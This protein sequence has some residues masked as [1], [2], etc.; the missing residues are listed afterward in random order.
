ME[1]FRTLVRA[2]FL[3]RYLMAFFVHSSVQHL[4]D[5]KS[6]ASLAILWLFRDMCIIFVKV[7]IESYE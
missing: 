1:R 4:F 5:R 7:H 2:P 3:S 6:I